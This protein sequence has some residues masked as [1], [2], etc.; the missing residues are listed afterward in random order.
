MIVFSLIARKRLR[1]LGNAKGNRPV[2]GCKSRKMATA[3]VD[4]GT[5]CCT[6]IFMRVAGIR[7]SDFSKSNSAH[8]AWR[9]SPGRTNTSGAN[10][11]AQ[12]VIHAPS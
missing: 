11:K 8:C 6:R 4:S 7:H 12:R 9:S 2:S 3:W 10:R 1:T 5:M